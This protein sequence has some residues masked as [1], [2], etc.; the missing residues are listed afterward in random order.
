M[1]SLP[2][3][4]KLDPRVQRTLETFYHAFRDLLR[5]RH[6]EFIR[7]QDIVEKAKLNRATFYLHFENKRDF[8]CFATECG[9]REDI[10][11]RISESSFPYNQANLKL[12]IRWTLEHIAKVYDDW[13]YQWDEILFENGTRNA[14]Y[15]F[16]NN[17]ITINDDGGENPTDTINTCAM[18]LSSSL[19]GLGLMWCHKGHKAPVELLTDQITNLFTNGLPCLSPD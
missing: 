18:S 8:I 12:F 1:S 3:S 9:F 2:S 15:K 11:A 5:D 19:T 13:N 16:L 7:V 6:Y 14:I 4:E 17:W 10:G